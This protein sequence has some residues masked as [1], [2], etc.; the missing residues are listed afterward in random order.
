MKQN[1]RLIG[2]MTI[3]VL[4]GLSACRGLTGDQPAERQEN[5]TPTDTEALTPTETGTVKQEKT[6][7]TEGA[8]SQPTEESKA[9]EKPTARVGLQAT[10]PET[11]SLASG[12]IQLVEFFAFW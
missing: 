6:A 10:D 3:L 8:P 12:E 2:L 9:S 11:V 4:F 5:I 1:M 7:T